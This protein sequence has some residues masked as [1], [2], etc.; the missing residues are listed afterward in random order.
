VGAPERCKVVLDYRVRDD[1][2]VL[3]LH[4]QHVPL[5]RRTG[6]QSPVLAEAYLA[7]AIACETV[8]FNCCF[9]RGQS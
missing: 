3:G 7:T 5:E 9:G 1:V 2:V 8:L 4:D 6:R